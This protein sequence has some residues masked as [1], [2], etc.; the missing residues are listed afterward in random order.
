MCMIT[1]RYHARTFYSI[2]E[3][4]ANKS[5]SWSEIRSWTFLR[6]VESKKQGSSLDLD[7]E[8]PLD[9]LRAI[10]VS[11]HAS[12]RDNHVERGARL[13]SPR[14]RNVLRASR[15]HVLVHLTAP[16]KKRETTCSL[17]ITL[18]ACR[19]TAG[20]WVSLPHFFHWHFLSGHLQ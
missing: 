17:T 6:N 14:A 13:T 2:V 10:R 16:E 18:H 1:A 11:E 15:A 12:A 4:N 8:K 5:N 20:Q 7:Y 3:K 9:F 19:F